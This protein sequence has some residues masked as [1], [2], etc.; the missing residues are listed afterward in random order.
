MSDFSDAHSSGSTSY[1]VVS[2]PKLSAPHDPKVGPTSLVSSNGHDDQ[3]SFRH[4]PTKAEQSFR[5]LATYRS[6]VLK[7]NTTGPTCQPVC[8][9]LRP[10]VSGCSSFAVLGFVGCFLQKASQTGDDRVVVGY[11]PA[12]DS[13]VPVSVKHG[14]AGAVFDQDVVLDEHALGDL[15]R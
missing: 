5:C 9:C 4:P 11:G 12:G 7:Q 2:V 13:Q 14:L 8:H 10:E 15:R 6:Y 1:G 3:T